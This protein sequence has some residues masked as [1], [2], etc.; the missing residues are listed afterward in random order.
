MDS[1]VDSNNDA[2][3]AELQEI[4]GLESLKDIRDFAQTI[5]FP[6][7]GPFE[8][9]TETYQEIYW[10]SKYG[11]EDFFNFCRN[12]TDG[13]APENVTAV[14]NQLAKYTNG[15][16]WKNLGNYAAYIKRV[17]LPLCASGDYNSNDCFGTQ[18]ATWWANPTPSAE[19]TYLYSTCTEM[20]A[21]QAPMPAGEKSLL[22]RVIDANYTAQWCQWSFSPGQYNSIPATPD[23]SKWNSYGDFDLKAERL[24]FLDGSNDPW[25]NL[26][27]HSKIPKLHLKRPPKLTRKQVTTRHSSIGAM[28]TPSN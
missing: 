7:G 22:S 16:P 9:P 24:F 4:F 18:N 26:C 2:A 10:N 19:R 28:T 27:K 8:Y 23:L 13:D 3:L 12:V 15:E 21:Y 6:I 20:G 1:L 5:A 14:D 17:V 11:H 25:R